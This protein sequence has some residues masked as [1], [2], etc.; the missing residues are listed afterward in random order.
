MYAQI[1]VEIMPTKLCFNWSKSTVDIPPD[2]GGKLYL[3]YSE[4]LQL[5]I[6]NFV[7]VW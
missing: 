2:F 3:L 4:E 6:L 7:G 5:L 1:I